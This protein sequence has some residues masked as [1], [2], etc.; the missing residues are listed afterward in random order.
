[1]NTPLL[2]PGLPPLT[3][4]A[5]LST[6]NYIDRYENEP[7]TQVLPFLYVGNARDSSNRKLL[8]ELGIKYIL[9]V[10]THTP[11]SNFSSENSTN[12]PNPDANTNAINAEF[13]TKWIPV[14]DS[15]SENLATYFEDACDFI[16]KSGN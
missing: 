7:P 14:S 6:P 11:Q 2:F 9:S 16:G 12:E 13:R 4:S 5:T 10:T 8:K 3:P 15:L 1:M